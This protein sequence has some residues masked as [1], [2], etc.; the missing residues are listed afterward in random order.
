M[1]PLLSVIICSHNPR[2]DYLERTLQ[3]LK[4]QTLPLNQ[5]EL[6]LIDNAS[7]QPIAERWD[8]GWHPRARHILERTLGLT[9]ARLRGMQESVAELLV[10]VDDDN[11][12]CADY[13]ARAI[14][15]SRERP[16]IGAFG[17]SIAP[18][19][20]TTPP[21]YLKN[22]LS[23]LAVDEIAQDYWTNAPGW[24]KAHPF[25]AG[26]CVQ[27]SVAGAYRQATQKDPRRKQLGRIGAGLGS[28][29]DVD[30]IL[31]AIDLGMGVGRFQ[32]LK[33]THLIS[34]R[35]VSEDYIVRVASE[36]A[37]SGLVL[38]SVRNSE[39]HI[40]E[41]RWVTLARL[42]WRLLRADSFERRV[43]LATRRAQTRARRLLKSEL[44]VS[45]QGDSSRM[46]LPG[47]RNLRA[48]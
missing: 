29:D 47:E 18:E 21:N 38:S 3:G 45:K 46:M 42:C 26:L 41:P 13:L 48:S 11:V 28:H 37:A 36:C 2:L 15:I 8:L 6:L 33:L 10:F 5:W 4:A 1:K 40:P 9:A 23:Y 25:G 35:R 30:L 17:A 43:L 24:S 22:Y 32:S 31:C 19:F 39:S 20:E 27:R 14:S 44:F 16:Y 12:L 7:E 34:P